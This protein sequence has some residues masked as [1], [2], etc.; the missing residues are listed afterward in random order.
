MRNCGNC[1]N[2]H[3]NLSERGEELICDEIEYEEVITEEDCCCEEHR[4]YPGEEESKNYLF[5]D[6]SYLGPGYLIANVEDGKMNSFIKF[7]KVNENG[8]PFFAMRAFI[9]GA[10]ENPDEDFSTMSFTFRDLEDDENGLYQAFEQFC[11]SLGGKKI[12][13]IDPVSQGQNN[14]GLINN[15]HTTTITFSKDT[16][17]GTQHP[18]DYI[19]VLLGDDYSCECYNKSLEQNCKEELSE[20]DAKI[21]LKTKND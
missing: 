21:L 15:S 5:Y 16:Y 1:F 4:Y 12:K 14:I 10:Q 18:S 19:D 17:H 8:F 11:T 7:Y 9:R 3:Y 6:N 2:G 20:E 13:S